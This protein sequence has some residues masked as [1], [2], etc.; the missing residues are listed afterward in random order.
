MKRL[1][2]VILVRA[3]IT[4]QKSPEKKTFVFMG[5]WGVTVWL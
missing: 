4:E 3:G 2:I 1:K 5:G